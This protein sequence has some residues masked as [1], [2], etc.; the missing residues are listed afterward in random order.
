MREG[1]AHAQDFLVRDA[2][3]LTGMSHCLFHGCSTVRVFS[4]AVPGF[5]LD[6]PG[7]LADLIEGA[8]DHP[9]EFDIADGRIFGMTAKVADLEP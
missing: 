1:A 4:A 2:P 9:G 7:A 3:A 6:Q 8:R 5:L